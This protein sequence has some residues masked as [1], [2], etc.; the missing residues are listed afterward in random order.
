MHSG[1]SFACIRFAVLPSI[2]RRQMKHL[3]AL[4]GC[5][6]LEIAGFGSINSPQRLLANDL[7]PNTTL[8]NSE[9]T[10]RLVQ[11]AQD[12]LT[13]I[14]S[15]KI[16]ETAPKVTVATSPRFQMMSAGNRVIIL[17]TQTGETRIIES[18]GGTVHQNVEIGRSWITVTVLVNSVGKKK[19]HPKRAARD[20]VR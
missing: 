14:Q 3:T 11:P 18:D 17:D 8:K 10:N 5:L 16:S 12:G 1:A 2:E 6:F 20:K 13:E 7:V 15:E 9:L 19:S 4:V